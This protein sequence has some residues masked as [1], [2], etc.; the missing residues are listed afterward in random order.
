MGIKGILLRPKQLA[1]IIELDDAQKNLDALYSV[2]ECDCVDCATRKIGD[3]YYDIWCDDE[4]L[5]KHRPLPTVFT[6]DNDEIVEQICGNVFICKHNN[7]GGMKSLTDKELN[8]IYLNMGFVLIKE[9]GKEFFWDVVK[10][11]L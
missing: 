3:T 5:F 6:C 2:L 4:G 1:K 9:D 10:A 11:T 7:K 8:E